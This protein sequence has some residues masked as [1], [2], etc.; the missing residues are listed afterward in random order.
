MNSWWLLHHKQER[1]FE[2]AFLYFHFPGKPILQSYTKF[3]D[4]ITRAEYEKMLTFF[5]CRLSLLF[6]FRITSL[7]KKASPSHNCSSDLS[8]K[9]V[10]KNWQMKMFW[11]VCQILVDAWCIFEE[12]RLFYQILKID[13]CTK[14]FQTTISHFSIKFTHN[15][16]YCLFIPLENNRKP[17]GFLMFSGGYR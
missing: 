3:E 6:F 5:H 13:W 4:Q 11:V 2:N 15:S 10:K 9:P 12:S 1:K 14:L 8:K 16:W 7:C 17:L